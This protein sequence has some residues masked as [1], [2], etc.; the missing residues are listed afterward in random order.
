M[1]KRGDTVSLAV[2]PSDGEGE[3][4]AYTRVFTVPD[5][6]PVFTSTP[7]SH[8]RGT[9][10]TYRAVAVDPDG[11]AVTYLLGSA[12][13]GMSIDAKTGILTWQLKSADVG[14][15]DIEVTAQDPSGGKT[16]QRYSLTIE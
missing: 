4:R 8:F 16:T 13:Q 1:F 3:G 11:D 14:T 2:V 9:V 7:P 15:H 10:Y 5:A 12:P 6:C